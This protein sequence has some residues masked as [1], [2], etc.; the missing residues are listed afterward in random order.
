MQLRAS[1]MCTPPSWPYR[2]TFIIHPGEHNPWK[3][4]M[5]W[6]SLNWRC[7]RDTR[8]LAHERSVKSVKSSYPATVLTLEQI[9]NQMHKLEA[10]KALCRPNI[11]AAV[12]LSK[13][14][15]AK[16]L[17]FSAIWQLTSDMLLRAGEATL[18][19]DQQ[20]LDLQDANTSLESI[21]GTTVTKSGIIDVL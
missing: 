17:D 18:L 10:L 14:L 13:A 3:K 16:H 9:Y 11:T 7:C 5:Y 15:Q 21:T 6:T 8:W 4:Y 2:N 19:S 20:V 1:N 12:F